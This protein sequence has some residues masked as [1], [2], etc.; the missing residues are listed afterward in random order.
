MLHASLRRS[1]GSFI[2][3]VPLSYVE[4]NHL[5]AGARLA[6]EIVGDELK[7]KPERSRPSLAE[8]WPRLKVAV[9]AGRDGS[10]GR[11]AATSSPL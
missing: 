5:D 1:G 7:I 10:R 8:L 9:K 3:T 11:R 2:M 4:Q 6:L